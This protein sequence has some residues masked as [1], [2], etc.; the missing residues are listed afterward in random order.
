MPTAQVNGISI[1]YDELGEGPALLLIMG[2]GCQLIH[3][4]DEFRQMLVDHGFR[5]I[6]MD[7]RD[8]GLSTH[9]TQQRAPTLAQMAAR[10]TVGLPIEAPYR[11]EDMAQDAVGLLDVLGIDQ[12]LVV[13]ASMGGMIGQTLAIENPERVRGLVSIM[14]HTG[15][16][17]FL[18]GRP[19]AIK[20][21]LEGRPPRTPEEAGERV[22][23][24]MDA[25]ASPAY[26]TDP[27]RYREMAA[28]AFER[29]SD[30]RGFGRQ[31][32]A[33]LSSGSRAQGLEK[34]TVPTLVIHG[35]E[36]PLIPVA[37]GRRTAKLIP[38]AQLWEVDGMG[39][40]L[41]AQLWPVIADRISE[42]ARRESCGVA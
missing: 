4:R 40:D 28:I 41:P 23:R 6:R 13:G 21:M 19:N 36:D 22:V 11:L 29:D 18:V 30:P 2:I 3:W 9:L 20:V 37:A 34:L 27:D 33:I 32:A 17:R 12:A 14:S 16:R 1:C 5:V 35:K 15:E 38:D 7:N 24:I 10:R 8:M 42:F 26:P 39:H 25:L 31:L